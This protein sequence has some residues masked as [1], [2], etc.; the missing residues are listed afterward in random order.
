MVVESS[1]PMEIDKDTSLNTKDVPMTSAEETPTLSEEEEARQAIDKLRG[2]D[3]SA[4]IEAAHQLE[5]VARTLGEER[6][7]EELLPFLTDGVDDEEDVLAAI[8]MSLGK[9]IPY[10]GGSQ[11]IH[12]LLPPL[13]LLLAVEE[14]YVRENAQKSAEQIANALPGENFHKEYAAMVTRLATKEWFTARVSACALISIPFNR[15]IPSE[16]EIQCQHFANL[17]RDDV[18]MVRRVAAHYLGQM[19]TNIVDVQAEHCVGPD[20]MLTTTFMSL[21]EELASNEQPDSVRLH[22]AQNCVAFGKGMS[23]VH[24]LKGRDNLNV[25]AADVLIKRIVPLVVATI[26]D[27]SWRVRW[28]AAS[29][30]AEVVA[31]FEKLPGTMDTL[32]PAYEKLLQDPEAEVRT[33][34]TLNLAEIAKCK[35]TVPSPASRGSSDKGGNESQRPRTTVA[36]RLVKKVTALTEDDSENVRASL[37]MVASELAPHLGK[38]ATITDLVPPV[39][40]LLRDTASSEVRLNVISSLGALNE[41]IGVDLLSQS[42]L[43]AI[44]D[45]AEDGKWRIRLAIM[46][47]IPH[48]AKHLGKDFFSNEL[49]ALCIG[50]L[51][52]DISSIREAGAHNLKELTQIFGAEWAIESLLPPLDKVRRHQSY[53]RRL[54]AAHA[55]TLMATV[56]EPPEIATTEILPM[57]L[58]MATDNVR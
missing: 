18:P 55:F 11:Y 56:I 23:K 4:R 53:L 47:H 52:D 58:L 1:N 20:G 17:C 33:S 19:V 43:P 57:I 10:V 14:N 35:C 29:K 6:T 38:E 12:T 42:L 37:A 27:R 13:E 2:E 22:T 50:W 39:L 3:L 51:G 40:L 5:S 28:T 8:A 49:T 36:K 15:F 16:Q 32:I 25:A 26:D 48:L 9:L 30:F 21:F 45:L 46:Q 7:R 34:A 31:A 41:V 54:T 24:A 44:K